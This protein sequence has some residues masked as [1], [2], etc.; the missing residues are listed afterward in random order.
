[1]ANKIESARERILSAVGYTKARP[2]DESLWRRGWNDW[3]G[4][5][6]DWRFALLDY[7]GSPILG[8][9][10]EPLVG[11]LAGI[12]EVVVLW[13]SMTVTAP[14]R[15]RNEARATAAAME[16]VTAQRWYFRLNSVGSRREALDADEHIITVGLSITN[17]LDRRAAIA[18]FVLEASD[19][20]G[21]LQWLSSEE[22]LNS[23]SKVQDQRRWVIGTHDKAVLLQAPLRFEPR[24]VNT[25]QLV[26]IV[27]NWDGKDPLLVIRDEDGDE[28][29]MEL[30]AKTMFKI[31][32]KS[33][34]VDYPA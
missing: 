26:F 16:T 24:D 1:M 27:R 5:L 22:D 19:K 14:L 21:V 32:S 20:D 8:W 9:V 18:D 28:Y 25:G 10:T 7:A 4:G 13:I 12:G 30:N 6:L 3:K 11:V 29:R 17:R 33:R 34:S 31:A 23:S 2:P 15:Q